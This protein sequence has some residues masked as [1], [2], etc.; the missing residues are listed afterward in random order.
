MP[1]LAIPA[2]ILSPAAPSKALCICPM[3]L[4]MK[5][6]DTTFASAA[7]GPIGPRLKFP[8]ASPPTLTCS[9][10]SG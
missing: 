3:S 7:I 5:G 10:A 9:I 2:L 6:K 4:N 1:I 8:I